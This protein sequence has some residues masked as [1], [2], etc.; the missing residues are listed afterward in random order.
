[1]VGLRTCSGCAQVDSVPGV[2]ND[3]AERIRPA[4]ADD[5]PAVRDVTDGQG[6]GRLLLR[7]VDAHARALGLG[8]IRLCTA[9][10]QPSGHQVRATS[11]R[12]S[13][14]PAGRSSASSRTR[15]LSVLFRGFCTVTRRIAASFSAYRVP[16]SHGGGRL[17]GEFL[18]GAGLSVSAVTSGLSVAGVTVG[19]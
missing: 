19:A 10:G 18:I 2:T 14:R 1:M 13:G 17:R 8:E 9:A 15:R 16:R 11:L 5:V 4:V 12:T 6:V 3:V 7:F